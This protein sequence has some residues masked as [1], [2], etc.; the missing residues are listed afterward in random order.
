MLAPPKKIAKDVTSMPNLNQRNL[1]LKRTNKQLGARIEKLLTA[2]AT[3]ASA[4][5]VAVLSVPSAEAKVIYTPTK[6]TITSSYMLDLNHDGIP[7]FDIEYCFCL[8]HGAILQA[9][10]V[11]QGNEVRETTAAPNEAADLPRNTVIGPH[12]GFTSATQGYG[13][14]LMGFFSAYGS[15][16]FSGGPWIGATNRYLG[17]KFLINGQIHYGW[18]RLTVTQ[19]DGSVTLNGYAYETVPKKSIKAGQTSGASAEEARNETRLPAFVPRGPSLGML[20]AGADTLDIWRR[21]EGDRIA[22]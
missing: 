9:G 17:L 22:A 20:A 2:Y 7:D 8:P 6:V 3:V 10:L 15:A 11:T 5:G 1:N 14:V 19:R 4:A 18:A 12:E 16:S 13:G 21:N